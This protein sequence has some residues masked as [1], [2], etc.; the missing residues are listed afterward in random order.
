MPRFTPGP[1]EAVVT[2]RL[3]DSMIYRRRLSGYVTKNG[4]ELAIENAMSVT[5][6]PFDV[7]VTRWN[8]DR[9]FPEED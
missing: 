2:A 9:P 6:S 5:F 7:K 1:W 4:L 3:N 8:Y